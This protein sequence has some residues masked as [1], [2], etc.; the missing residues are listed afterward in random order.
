MCEREVT[1]AC[2]V[3]FAPTT[4]FPTPNLSRVQP[5]TAYVIRLEANGFS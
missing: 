2:K 4:D 3:A 5:D 1:I